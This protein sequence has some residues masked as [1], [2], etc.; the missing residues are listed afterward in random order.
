MIKKKT[1]LVLFGVLFASLVLVF[2]ITKA[3]SWA[4]QKKNIRL[5]TL[6]NLENPLEDEVNPEFALLDDGHMVDIRCVNHLEMLLEAAE[7]AGHPVIVVEAYISRYEQQSLFD[8]QVEALRASGMTGEAALAEAARTVPP[9]GCSEHELGLAVDLADAEHPAL[10]DAQTDAAAQS[11][12]RDNCWRYGFILRYPE[13]KREVTGVGFIPW[14]Y[15][16]VGPEAAGQMHD[17]NVTL[18]EYLEMFYS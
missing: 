7:A 9:A 14:H 1:V 10:D 18:E 6:V 4:A 8:E 11:W 3:G 12:L 15:R 16:Y 2:L 13:G 17:L 5:L